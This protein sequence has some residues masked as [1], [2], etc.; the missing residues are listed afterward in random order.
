MKWKVPIKLGGA[1][2]ITPLRPP[3]RGASAVLWIHRH[4]LATATLLS[5]CSQPMITHQHKFILDMG[6]QHRVT[7]AWRPFIGPTESLLNSTLPSETFLLSFPR[8]RPVWWPKSLL[9]S[10]A[11]LSLFPSQVISP[12]CP[13]K[14]SLGSVPE[15][16][17][18]YIKL[19]YCIT[20]YY[21]CLMK[22]THVIV[23]AVSWASDF[24][25][26]IPFWLKR[27]TDW[28]TVVIQTWCGADVSSEMNEVSLPF[29]GKQMVVLLSTIKFELWS[30]NWNFEK[31]CI[32]TMSSTV[33]Q[34]SLAFLVR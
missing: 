26:R 19:F 24:F 5:V 9:A 31:S 17:Y 33:S 4:V 18:M 32:F 21:D 2:K 7:L 8:V 27:M 23:C 29:Q 30:T 1:V 34:C 13:S 3:A 16:S 15:K 10:L 11:L 22:T 12:S 14:L 25:H 20:K 28:Q 6:F